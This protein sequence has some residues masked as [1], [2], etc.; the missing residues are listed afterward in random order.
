MNCPFC[1]FL[2]NSVVDTFKYKD[3]I[4]RCRKCQKCLKRWNTLEKEIKDSQ[5]TSVRS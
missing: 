4:Y 5:G 1:H 2:K 3:K